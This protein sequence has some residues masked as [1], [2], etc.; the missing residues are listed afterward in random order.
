MKNILQLTTNSDSKVHFEQL[1]V[2]DGPGD[3]FGHTAVCDASFGGRMIVFSGSDPKGKFP[4][5]VWI[6]DLEEM[7]WRCVNGEDCPNGRHFHSAVFYDGSMWIFGGTSNGIHQDLNVF[8]C[9]SLKWSTVTTLGVAPCPRY[10]H[11][12][13]VHN[14]IMYV[15]GG[16]DQNGFACNDLYE[17]DLASLTWSK[18]TISGVV[19]KEAY[20]HSGVVHKGSMYCFGGYRK[21]YNEILEYR[22]ATKSWSFLQTSGNAPMPRWGHSAVVYGNC[23]YVVGGRD[24][25][26]NF[27][28][29]YCF[30]FDTNVWKKIECVGMEGRFFSSAILC[31]D[32]MYIF[33]GRNIHAFCFND[34]LFH[35][36]KV[37]SRFKIPFV[38]I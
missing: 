21:A 25:V 34:T 29:C 5:D 33:G 26:T 13:V 7:T 8:N 14:D 1:D 22:F 24:R 38:L 28:D 37:N 6:L 11:C 12:S 10:G 30:N 2:K 36:L 27:S 19:P 9:S 18:P 17:F 32:S 20:H 31:N 3:L 23:M 35:S 16:Y 4:N 15:F